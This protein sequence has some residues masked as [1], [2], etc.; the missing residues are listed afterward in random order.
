[1]PDAAPNQSVNPLS[2]GMVSLGG[3]KNFV[4]AEVML[5]ALMADGLEVRVMGSTNYDLIAEP[6]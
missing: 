5:G 1:V 4:D 6:V 3:A 2:V